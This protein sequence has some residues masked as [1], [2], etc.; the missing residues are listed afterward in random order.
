MRQT[1]TEAAHNA[2][3]PTPTL[4]LTLTPQAIRP[5]AAVKSA[6]PSSQYASFRRRRA[7]RCL[8]GCRRLLISPHRR[9]EGPFLSAQAED[10]V[11]IGGLGLHRARYSALKGP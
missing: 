4:K 3:S 5:A 7:L 9:P 8:S 6:I 2:Y 11:G 1:G 10:A